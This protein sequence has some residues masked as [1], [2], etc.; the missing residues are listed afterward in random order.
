MY[1][2]TCAYVNVICVQHTCEHMHAS[3]DADVSSWA[4]ADIPSIMKYIY[5]DM[6]VNIYKNV[7]IHVYMYKHARV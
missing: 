6:Y 2:R 7:R 4:V 5:I 3:K 1:V